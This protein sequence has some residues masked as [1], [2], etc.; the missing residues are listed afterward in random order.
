[1]KPKILL[2]V[3]A[4]LAMWTMKRCY[5]GAAAGDLWWIL[6][7]T[8]SLVSAA[9]GAAFVPTG[10]GYLAQERLFLI[11]KSCAGI[12]FAIAA[13]GMLTLVFF[14]RATSWRSA[15]RVLAV[16]ALVS[17]TATVIVNA[18][19]IAIAMWLAVHP[20]LSSLTAAS[21]HRV[22]GILVYFCG[23]M[24]LYALAQR[25]DRRTLD[26]GSWIYPL[27]CYYAVTIAIPI[28]NGNGGSRAFAAH[29]S[30]VLV[31]PVLLI[32]LAGGS[33]SLI[34][35]LKPSRYV[36]SEAFAQLHPRSRERRDRK[37]RRD[38]RDSFVQKTAN[39]ACSALTL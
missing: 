20:I 5:A 38:R 22:E 7:P 26:R 32:A 12:N 15:A 35:R 30:V 29:A 34:A 36:E 24:V 6:G 21:V 2:A 1:V 4:A 17:Y 39:S 3:A 13:F 27:I 19:R 18:A 23:L 8:A 14:H 16:S 10:D 33:V 37:D 25:F 11:E 28:A 9:T 31:V